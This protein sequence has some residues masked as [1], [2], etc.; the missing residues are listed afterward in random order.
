MHRGSS[1]SCSLCRL[2]LRGSTAA[3]HAAGYGNIRSATAVA[4]RP[5]G[6]LRRRPSERMTVKQRSSRLSASF[7]IRRATALRRRSPGSQPGRSLWGQQRRRRSR[8]QHRWRRRWL[9]LRDRGQGRRGRHADDVV[10]DAEHAGRGRPVRGGVPGHQGQGGQRRSGH[11]AVHQAAHGA[12]RPAAAPPTWRRSSTSTSRPSPSPTACSTCAPYGA[13]ASRASSSTGPGRRSAARTARSGRPAGHRPDGHAVPQGHL[14]QVRHRR[15]PRP[16]TSSPPRR[17]LHA[18]DPNIYLHQPRRQPGRPAGTGC[19][20]QA[21]A[22]PVRSTPGK[23]HG[24]HQRQRRDVQEARPA[25]WGGLAKEGVVGDRPGL[26]RRL[27]PGSQQRQVR[28]LAHRRLGPG[29]PVGLGEDHRGQVAGGPAAAVGRRRPRL[30][31]T[32][33]AR[34]PR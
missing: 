6:N 16:G 26:H 33:A 3:D 31:A 15:S 29:L 30:R 32:G 4:A 28:H 11:A 21:G 14:R 9:L 1:S 17:K 23:T 27:V 2:Y 10:M 20:W 18:A 24:R 12:A 13:A 34:P 8:H 5:K 19:S 22:K 25:Y 7:P